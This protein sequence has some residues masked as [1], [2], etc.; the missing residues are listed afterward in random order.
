MAESG[1]DLEHE[2][3]LA[4]KSYVMVELASTDHV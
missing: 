3:E 2:P 4:T 1:I